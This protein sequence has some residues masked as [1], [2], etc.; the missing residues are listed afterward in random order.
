MPLLMIKRTGPTRMMTQIQRISKRSLFMK[1]LSLKL[2][3]HIQR[4]QYLE[5][6]LQSRSSSEMINVVPD[7]VDHVDSVVEGSLVDVLEEVD[8]S[9]T[10]VSMRWRMNP[11]Q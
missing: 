10:S 11:S 2:R 4:S 1:V 7:V 5:K 8:G 9:R 3:L 6:I